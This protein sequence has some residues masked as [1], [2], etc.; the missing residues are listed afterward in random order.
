[1][2][3]ASL[4]V[5]WNSPSILK[6]LKSMLDCLPPV[7]KPLRRNGGQQSQSKMH[8]SLLPLHSSHCSLSEQ[9]GPA[10]HRPRLCFS[11]KLHRHPSPGRQSH[12][13]EAAPRRL[14]DKGR[15]PL[16]RGQCCWMS[17]SVQPSYRYRHTPVLVGCFLSST[18]PCDN[19]ATAFKVC[20]ELKGTS[21]EVIVLDNAIRQKS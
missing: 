1:M 7:P 11:K 14:E 9:Q 8:G 17:F 16:Q 18:T 21:E 2:A 5:A 13:S 6:L 20:G 10:W 19:H 15:L 12:S 3:Q 4:Q